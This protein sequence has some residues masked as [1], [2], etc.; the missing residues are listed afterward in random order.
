MLHFA[1]RVCLVSKRQ[2]SLSAGKEY[3]KRVLALRRKEIHRPRAWKDSLL[4]SLPLVVLDCPSALP[5]LAIAVPIFVNKT[6]CLCVAGG[7]THLC[8]CGC[9]VCDVNSADL[10]VGPTAAKK[11]SFEIVMS[12]EV[13]RCTSSAKGIRPKLE[14]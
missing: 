1:S 9:S 11:S 3:P 13:M 4:N 8:E 14:V 2:S 10:N 5:I 6:L 12:L 7:Q